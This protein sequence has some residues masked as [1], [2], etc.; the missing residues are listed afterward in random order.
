MLDESYDQSTNPSRAQCAVC[1]CIMP[2]TKA[3]LVTGM[4]QLATDAPTHAT[5][6]PSH[7]RT[8]AI[9]ARQLIPHR[10][11]CSIPRDLQQRS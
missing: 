6:Q 8:K 5:G 9:K 7:T 1:S 3:G 4:D 11:Q 10:D 2:V